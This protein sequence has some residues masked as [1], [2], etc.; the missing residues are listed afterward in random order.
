MSDNK[1]IRLSREEIAKLEIGHTNVS[2]AQ[3][4]SLT[5]F[6]LLFI[7]IYP[8]LQT[9]YRQPFAEWRDAG[10]VQQSIKAYETAI[11]DSSLLR[12]Y[13]L[14]PVQ[15]WLTGTLKT[16]NEKVIVGRDGWLFFSGDCEYLLNPGFLLPEK[17]HK[18]RLSGVQ[19]DPAAAILDFN[20][21]LRGRGIRLI[22]LPVPVKPMIYPDKLG[23]AAAPLQ[24][25]SWAEFKK[26]M[27]AEGVTVIDLAAELSAMRSDG[28]EPYLKTDTHWTPEAMTMAAE[29]LARSI[30]GDSFNRPDMAPE[31]RTAAGDIAAM[32]KLPDSTRYFPAE[33]VQLLPL[34]GSF[35][36]E[37]E[38]LLLGDSFTNIY[39]LEAMNWGTGSGLAEHLAY[40]LGRPVDVIARN[41]AGAF[42]TRQLLAG[43]LKRGR[44][45]L[46]GKTTVVWEFAI[47]ELANGDWKMLDM[48]PGDP[49]GS[50]LLEIVEPR[51]A[52]ATVLAVS[53]VP[54]PNSAPYKDFVMS[55]YLG[56]IDGG[57]DRVLAYAAGMRDNVRTEEAGLRPGDRVRVRLTPWSE[58]EAQYGSWSRGEFDDD[59]LLLAAPCWAELQKP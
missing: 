18:R 1:K 52:I 11:E 5:L 10:T 54:R 23:G 33:T 58:A 48:T 24:N 16:G 26:Q 51:T 56:D 27:E 32:L 42:A 2:T 8:I 20:R 14:S 19:P 59:E 9:V 22:L 17:L 4:W 35:S 28:V 31:S 40:Y 36:R 44:D 21:Q 39:S 47:R 3:K 43:E 38:V 6:F 45:R 12:K 49:P 46:A 13:L 25:P 53:A 7:A 50:E 41:D 34:D 37:S 57:A 30:S 29:V 55:I 15:S